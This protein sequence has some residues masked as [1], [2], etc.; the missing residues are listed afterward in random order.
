M[1]P[2]TSGEKRASILEA[3]RTLLTRDGLDKW[4][5][6]RVARAAGCAK[7][8][9][10]YHFR[11]R[12]ALLAEVGAAMVSDAAE[13]RTKELVGTGTAALDRLWREVEREVSLGQLAARLALFGVSDKAVRAALEPTQGQLSTFGAAI[14]GALSIHDVTSAESRG[15][16]ATLDGLGAALVTGAPQDAIH[17]GFDRWWLT[18]LPPA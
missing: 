15:S 2:G 7:G 11:G 10:H 16:W 12:S 3:A 9:V 13:R 18:L 17:E 5:T 6:E 1:S 8:L 4:S 14:A